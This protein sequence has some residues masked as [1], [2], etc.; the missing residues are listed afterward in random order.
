VEQAAH[1]EGL[2]GFVRNTDDGKVEAQVEG[3]RDAVER[4]ERAIR[5]G[6]SAARVDTVDV[7][8]VAPTG[9]QLGF[10]VRG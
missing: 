8:D 6:P 4:F 3:D 2:S 9:R 7:T 10:M 1:R 5:R